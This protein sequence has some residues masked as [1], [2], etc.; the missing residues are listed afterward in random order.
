MQTTEDVKVAHRH[1]TN[2]TKYIAYT[3]SE[4]FKF[5]IKCSLSCPIVYSV[6]THT[7]THMHTQMHTTHIHCSV[8]MQHWLATHHRNKHT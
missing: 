5:Q 6:H 1:I 4:N 3:H 8:R 2:L 7:Y